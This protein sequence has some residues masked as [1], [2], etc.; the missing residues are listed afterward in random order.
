MKKRI[1]SLVTVIAIM[2]GLLSGVNLTAFAEET[3]PEA[4]WGTSVDDLTNSGTFTEAWTA[5]RTRG[6]NVKYI[7]LQ[8]DVASYNPGTIQYGDFTIDLNGKTATSGT[9]IYTE[10]AA[11]ITIT[12]TSESRTGKLCGQAADQPVVW[13]AGTSTVTLE[14]GTIKRMNSGYA[15][16]TSGGGGTFVMKGGRV[17]VTNFN[18]AFQVG[19]GA[20]SAGNFIYYAGDIESSYADVYWSSGSI[21]LSNASA[22]DN[23][24]FYTANANV[25]SNMLKLPDGFG[26]YTKAE[27][28]VDVLAALGTY[29]V[30]RETKYNI[31]VNETEGGTV[32]V[33]EQVAGG[34]TVTFTVNPESGYILDTIT[35]TDASGNKVDVTDNKFIMPKSNTSI[36]VTFREKIA[37][38]I[39]VMV[40]GSGTVTPTYDNKTAYEGDNVA[41]T[42]N[43]MED[44]EL[45]SLT[46]T[47]VEGNV[48]DVTNNQFIMPTSNVT[49][50]A[51][52]VPTKYYSLTVSTSGNG[53]ITHT[54]A[55]NKAYKDAKITLTVT[56]DEGYALYSMTVTD[57]EGKQITVT[58]NTFTMPASNV[59]INAVFKPV[60]TITLQKTGSGSVIYGNKVVYE[61]DLVSLMITPADG[62]VLDSLKVTDVNGSPITVTD[63][64]FT[65][66]AS[67]VTISVNFKEIT[68]AMVVDANGNEIGEYDS[69]TDALSDAQEKEG[70]TLKLIRNITVSSTQNIS[71][72][73]FTIDLNG[74]RFSINNEA[75]VLSI[76][77]NAN[78]TIDDSSSGKNGMISGNIG[79]I[80]VDGHLTVHGGMIQCAAAD[81]A[82]GST[83]NEGYVIKANSGAVNITGGT[84]EKKKNTIAGYGAIICDAATVTITGGII[85]SNSNA[86]IHY[87]ENA[88]GKVI[89]SLAEG[90]MEGATFTDG[91]GIVNGTLADIL[92]EGVVYCQG[93]TVLEIT[94]NL[95]GLNINEQL[96]NENAIVIKD[97]CKMEV[98][99]FTNGVCTRCEKMNATLAGSNLTLDGNI[100]LNFYFE[101]D[102]DIRNN[103]TAFVQFTLEDGR[104]IEIATNNG[105]VNTTFKPGKTLYKFT[106]EVYATQMADTVIAKVIMGENTSEEYKHSVV[107]YAN[108]LIERNMDSEK[109]IALVKAMLNYGAYAQLNFDYNIEKLANAGLSDED[110]TS[111]ETSLSNVTADT[112]KDY[113][114]STTTIE[115]MGTFV[116]SSL[117]LDSET[118]VKVY[119]TPADDVDINSLTFSLGEKTLT[120]VKSGEYY[121][122]SITN[123]ASNALDNKFEITVKENDTTKGTF[124]CSAYAYCYNVLKSDS[125]KEALKNVVK[126]LYLYN[127]AADNYK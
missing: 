114:V 117:V 81:A 99:S 119:F 63:Y 111:Y 59:T 17:E 73:T 46:V 31:T 9:R 76:G 8:T 100:G 26:I 71:G 4:K 40:E 120:P 90:K 105:V 61:G 37:Y 95:N 78:V 62:F 1:L 18:Y 69:I 103:E 104:V 20:E 14:A 49:V 77:A 22:P 10:K 55:D 39:K 43:A 56:P 3:I 30:M 38:D 116:G 44:W 102:E 52:F 34:R 91:I 67:N 65:M 88:T 21:D 87:M 47:D 98:H 68:A 19:Y 60:Y 50:Y 42:V 16:G 5:A 125:C 35:V 74:F 86:D 27:E 13:V 123:I 84:L 23:I 94:D 89:L 108:A 45:K 79:V 57:E 24:T 15:A 113:T 101:L 2:M 80:S 6:S 53:A 28:P 36:K 92:G 109:T 32:S 66:P 127:V 93:D 112:F 75:D 107:N 51:T 29:K 106:C 122:I 54:Y 96:N 58:D 85:N 83:K 12:D 64:K 70:S 25:Q 118:T 7:Q 72:G 97:I 33:P 115:G 48:V 82:I 41:L 126:A 11:K 124:T 110:K 121:V